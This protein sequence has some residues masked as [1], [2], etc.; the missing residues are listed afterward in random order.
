MLIIAKEQK[1]RP[2]TVFNISKY[3]VD[4]ALKAKDL[5]AADIGNPIVPTWTITPGLCPH[6]GGFDVDGGK[7]AWFVPTGPTH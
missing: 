6:T 3:L 5:P 4:A 1:L 2:W 7:P